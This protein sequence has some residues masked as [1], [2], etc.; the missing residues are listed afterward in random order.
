MADANT[1]SN[2]VWIL[3]NQGDGTFAAPVAYGVGAQPFYVAAGD[4]D[5]DGDADLAVTVR[6]AISVL[7]NQ[8]VMWAPDHPCGRES[9]RSER[10]ERIG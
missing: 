4:L 6:S 3:R 5:G 10:R 7:L 8:S 2:S 1:P 9:A